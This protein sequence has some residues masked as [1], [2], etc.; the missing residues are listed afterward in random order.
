MDDATT[1]QLLEWVRS[2]FFGKYRGTRF[3]AVAANDPDYLRWIIEKSELDDGVKQ[4][5][6]Y[7]LEHA[8]QAQS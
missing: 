3:D 8:S 4:S 2:R 1:G 7:W 6:A 5:A